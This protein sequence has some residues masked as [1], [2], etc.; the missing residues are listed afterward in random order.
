MKGEEVKRLTMN[1]W[2]I[3]LFKVVQKLFPCSQIW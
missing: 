1:V 3:S 2:R